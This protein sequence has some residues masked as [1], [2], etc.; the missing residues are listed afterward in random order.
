MPR[1]ALRQSRSMNKYVSEDRQ[2]VDEFVDQTP[3][4]GSD[5]STDGV[6][7]S[8]ASRATSVKLILII[9]P[10]SPTASH[11]SPSVMTRLIFP[12]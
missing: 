6:P 11:N 2:V 3:R 1:E 4:I 12:S 9:S 8:S 7:P 5:F 10:F